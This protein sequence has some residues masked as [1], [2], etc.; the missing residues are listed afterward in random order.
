VI[1]RTRTIKAIA[2]ALGWSNSAIG[3]ARY[4]IN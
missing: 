1:T 4:V 3:S 2:A